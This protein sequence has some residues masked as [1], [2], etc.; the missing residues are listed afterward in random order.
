MLFVAINPV[1][2]KTALPLSLA[3]LVFI[4]G[5]LLIR[6][7]R[8]QVAQPIEAAPVRITGESN[9]ATTLAAYEG[10]I[11]RMKDQERELERL[12]NMER[13]R[14]TALELLSAAV[15]SNLSSGVVVFSSNGIVRNANESAKSILGYASPIGLHARDVF[16]GVRGVRLQ[17]GENSAGAKALLTGLE[18]SLKDGIS[19]RR[20]EADYATPQNH[21]RVLGITISPV[22]SSREIDAAACLISDLTEITN[23]NRQIRLKENLA[24]LGEMSAGI[25]HEFKNSLATISGYAQM[26]QRESTSDLGRD[27]SQKIAE[28]TSA[29]TRIVADFLN[30]ARPQGINSEMVFLRPMLEESARELGLRLVFKDFSQHLRIRGDSTA[31]HQVFRNLLRNSAEAARP[32]LPPQVEARGKKERGWVHMELRDNGAGIPSEQLS[33][34]FIPF[35]TTKSSGTGLGLALVHR[36]ITEHAGTIGVTSDGSGTTFSIA[37]PAEMEV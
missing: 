36:I 12:R 29:L 10:V 19:V 3:V 37:L 4:A 7:L 1:L 34:V 35:F 2:A 18:C 14:A 27:F 31:L 24:A 32:G 26:L 33:K 30:F 21:A 25:A 15:L 22:R 6:H 5:V 23:L 9:P 16:R 28:E 8:T 20:L 17:S 11:R 13:N